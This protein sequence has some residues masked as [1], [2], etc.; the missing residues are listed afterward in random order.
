MSMLGHHDLPRGN[1]TSCRSSCRFHQ[2]FPV[3]AARQ[4]AHRLGR[5]RRTNSLI[6]PPLRQQLKNRR[7]KLSVRLPRLMP[8]ALIAA[9]LDHVP[10]P[11]PLLAPLKRAPTGLA[12]LVL[13]RGRTFGLASAVRHKGKDAGSSRTTHAIR[14]ESPKIITKS[15]RT[16]LTSKT[17]CQNT[18]SA[19]QITTTSPQKTTT[20]R[21]K[22]SKTPCKRPLRYPDI[23]FPRNHPNLGETCTYP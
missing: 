8:P 20:K 16:F 17:D 1:Q 18:T 21:T 11:L 14:T 13:V 10:V 23:F 3:P 9:V 4:P 2:P 7:L 12:D 5:L 19:T 22:I 15:W 6:P